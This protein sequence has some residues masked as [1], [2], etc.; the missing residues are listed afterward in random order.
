MTLADIPLADLL[1]ELERRRVVAVVE[2]VRAG[3]ASAPDAWVDAKGSGIGVR[4]FRKAVRDGELEVHR[5]G[6]RDL[7]RRADVDR[8]I[9][10][11]PTRERAAPSTAADPIERA[12]SA[13]RLRVV[14]P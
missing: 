11:Q 6:R 8:W 3:L 14:R 13:G 12:I 9:R 1:I 10:R 2:G 7:A 4:T 5:V